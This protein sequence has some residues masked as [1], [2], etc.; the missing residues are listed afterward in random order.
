MKGFPS[1]TFRLAAALAL[2]VTLLSLGGMALQYRLVSDRLMAEAGRLLAADL[3]GFATLYEQRRIIAL[4]QAIEYRAASG[5]AGE[6]LMLMNRDGSVLAGTHAGWPEGV[7]VSGAGFGAPTSW[8][9]KMRPARRTWIPG[10]WPSVTAISDGG[11]GMARTAAH[12]L[13]RLFIFITSRALGASGSLFG[14][15]GSSVN[16]H[17]RDL[18]QPS[19]AGG[20]A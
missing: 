15:H 8:R 20:A 5:A 7:A 16:H 2:A 4:R 11:D 12:S 18:S 10:C 19:P 14:R 13:G 6:M 3:D 9:E 17:A 1:A